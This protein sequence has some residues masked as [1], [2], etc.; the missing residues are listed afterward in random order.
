MAHSVPSLSDSIDFARVQESWEK[1]EKILAHMA[2]FSQSARTSLRF[3]QAAFTQNIHGISSSRP[4]SNK[5][6]NTD[7]NTTDEARAYQSAPGDPSLLSSQD[8]PGL[9]SSHW[10][11]S[12]IG[13]ST[14]EDDLGLLSWIDVPDMWQWLRSDS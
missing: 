2:T 11:D 14:F 5:E 3:L 8:T 10:T 4:G 1:C 13:P 6:L 12:G 7:R 9:D